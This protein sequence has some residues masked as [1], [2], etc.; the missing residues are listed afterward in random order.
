VKTAYTENA[1]R[2]MAPRAERPYHHWDSPSGELWA[3]FFRH[4]GGHLI[5]F[6]DMADFE[7]S[8]TGLEVQSWPAPGT[9]ADTVAH[10]Y[11]NQ[12]LPLALSRQKRL[13]LH[14]SAV[15]I[16]AHGVAFLGESGMGKSTLAAGFAI[17]GFR[18]LT[19]DGLLLT[20][21]DG[22]CRVQP[23]HPSIRLWEDSEQALI[24]AHTARA[25]ALSFTSKSRLLAGASI[26]F[27]HEPKP[28]K[29]IFFLGDD[30]EGTPTITPVSAPQAVIGLIKNSFLLD[31][32]EQ[33]LL[34][35][36]FDEICKLVELAICYR[37]DYPRDY[38]A[39]PMVRASIV[40][41]VLERP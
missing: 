34:A 18:F 14:G 41:H 2:P 23:S 40:E 26:P 11:L 10:L 32:Q 6:P 16:D 25:P 27:C 33:D 24:G 38:E 4:V 7:V 21:H 39:L 3:Q 5:R 36:H 17:G 28:L 35:H 9:P 20:W 8:C 22:V 15:A 1:A 31:G 30:I 19:D 13:V 37:I 12:V 29:R